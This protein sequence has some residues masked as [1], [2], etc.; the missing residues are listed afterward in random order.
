MPFSSSYKGSKETKYLFI[1]GGFLRVLRKKFSNY[2]LDG[3][4]LELDY[5]RIRAEHT[6]VFYYDALPKKR[7][8]EKDAAF[9]DRVEQAKKE[10]ARIQSQNYVHSRIGAIDGNVN[11][12]VSQKGVDVRLTVDA[13]LHSIRGNTRNVTIFTSDSD[14]IPL[15]SALVENGVN[16]TLMYDPQKA[17]DF[18]IRSA[19]ISTP[20]TVNLFSTYLLEKDK[21]LF[22]SYTNG[23]TFANRGGLSAAPPK[24]V[25]K[26]NIDENGIRYK[27]L[28]LGKTYYCE[29][30]ENESKRY[31]GVTAYKDFEKL[32]CDIQWH[33]WLK[34]EQLEKIKFSYL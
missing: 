19:D 23:I 12:G 31:I 3:N 13:L 29:R 34:R 28:Q 15:L 33:N 9:A 32:F 25:C 7:E 16:V 6:K 24:S 2:F 27:F 20:I 11:E 1:D 30:Y 10:F 17:N 18:L 4:D 8:K 22:N 5:S 21:L 26:E 14:Y